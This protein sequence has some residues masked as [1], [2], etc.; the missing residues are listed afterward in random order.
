METLHIEFDI[1][2]EKSPLEIL[3]KSSED[4]KTELTHRIKQWIS[5][6]LKTVENRYKENPF[7]DFLD[8]IDKYAVDTG[9]EDLSINHECY[10]YGGPK[11]Q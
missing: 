11:R 3:G 6:Y 1:N 9:I 8:N 2:L 7:I 5:Q 4:L 10:L